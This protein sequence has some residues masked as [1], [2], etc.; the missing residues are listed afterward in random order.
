[1]TSVS[2]IYPKAK[3]LMSVGP[4]NW[5]PGS[6]NGCLPF[7]SVQNGVLFLRADDPNLYGITFQGGLMS[8]P[9]VKVLSVGSDGTIIPRRRVGN[10]GYN[11]Y[12]A[13]WCIPTL[14][15]RDIGKHVEITSID[16]SVYSYIAAFYQNLSSSLTDFN[17]E[18]SGYAKQYQVVY[19]NQYNI[20]NGKLIFG[21]TRNSTP[22]VG[23]VNVL[24]QT[25]SPNISTS[26]SYT[27]D[28]SPLR[29]YQQP[30]N[31]FYAIDT[32]IVISAIDSTNGD[33]KL[34]FV[35]QNSVAVYNSPNYS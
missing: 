30:Y 20:I 24:T 31:T 22:G 5:L 4:V 16:P 35:L 12:S 1:M 9:P 32:P 15:C 7:F 6:L 33:T 23:G 34:Y 18:E 29:T 28:G 17:L 21:G 8:L 10:K 14:P 27:Y 11:F 25:T 19:G 26:D 13:P 2:T 3:T